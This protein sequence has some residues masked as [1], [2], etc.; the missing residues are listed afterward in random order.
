[1]IPKEQAEKL[2]NDYDLDLFMEVSQKENKTD[3]ILTIA[4]N[5]LYNDYLYK[6]NRI[7]YEN[8]ES[9]SIKENKKKKCYIF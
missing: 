2:K 3:E 9:L 7:L 5:I 4:A 8:T 1:M 6:K